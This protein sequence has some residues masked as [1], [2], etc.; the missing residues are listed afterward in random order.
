M[1]ILIESV[2]NGTEPALLP[3][4]EFIKTLNPFLFSGIGVAFAIALSACGAAWGIALVGS[5]LTGHAVAR[6]H[7]RTRNIVRFVSIIQK[8]NLLFSVVFCEAVAIFGIIAALLSRLSM[9]T[10]SAT[11]QSAYTNKVL[12]LFSSYD[13]EQSFR[14]SL[15]VGVF[16]LDA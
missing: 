11:P 3:L 5:G 15:P 7:V 16:F 14:I 4:N 2:G 10:F 13:F 12:C 6:P 9:Q 8:L 1:D